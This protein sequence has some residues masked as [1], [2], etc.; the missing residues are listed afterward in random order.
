MQTEV[1]EE[2][3]AEAV[4]E[5]WRIDEQFNM[6]LIMAY[7]LFTVLQGAVRKWVMP[8]GG[9]GTLFMMIQIVAPFLFVSFLRKKESIFAYKPILIFT[10]LLGLMAVNPMNQTYFHGIL[11]FMLHLGQ[12]LLL[13]AYLNNREAFPL[14]RMTQFFLIVCGLQVLLATFQY[15]LPPNH[16]LNRYDREGDV[17][18]VAQVGKF[19]RVAGTFSYISGYGSMLNFVGFF[20]WSL[21][22]RQK[23]TPF[24]LLLIIGSGLLGCLMSGSRGVVGSYLIILT[25]ALLSYRGFGKKL[26]L[27]AAVL[28]ILGM[29]VALDLTERIPIF[30]NA[31]GA[32][33]ERVEENQSKG[34]TEGRMIEP[35]MEVAEFNGKY[36]LFGLGLGATYQGATAKWGTAYQVEEYG[37]YEEEG[38]RIMLE[39]GYLLFFA[40]MALWALIFMRSSLPPYFAAPLYVFFIFYSPSV[41]SVYQAFFVFMGFILVDNAFTLRHSEET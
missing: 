41:F 38:E 39:G 22:V 2:I 13:F 25:F 8:G 30:K 7:F 14:E 6:K 19:V 40:R 9:I 3:L 16:L 24:V 36:P 5:K 18:A 21:L 10:I 28:G 26:A 17:S 31:F 27:V 33:M 37:F 35:V 12:F 15:T 32:F 1:S 11:G 29:V 20:V 34:E 23:Q 4:V